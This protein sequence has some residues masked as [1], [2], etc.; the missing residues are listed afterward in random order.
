MRV[1]CQA[2]VLWAGGALYVW[3]LILLLPLVFSGGVLLG[4]VHVLPPPQEFM[5]LA[6]NY[7][8]YVAEGTL[9]ETC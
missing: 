8:A 5:S 3:G 2:R 7:N 1:L 4:M 6:V 9:R